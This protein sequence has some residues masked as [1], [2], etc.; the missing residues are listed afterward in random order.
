MHFG[1][2]NAP[3][4]FM[5]LM[6]DI[7]RPFTNSFVVVYLDDILIFNKSWAEHLQH[8]QQVLNTLWQQ[9]LYVNLEK[10]SFG[11]TRVQYLGYIMDEHGVH[12]DPTKIQAIR[13]W[14]APTTL[15]ELC[16]FLG[17]AN[18]YLRFMLGFSHIAWVPSQV[19][20]GGDKVKF[21]WVESL[22]KAFEELKHRLRL[23]SV[24]SLPNLQH[25]F[26][27]ETNASDYVVGIVL[28]QH[29]HPMAY[30]SETLSNA[31]RKYTTYDK[32]MYSIVTSLS[33]MEA[34]HSQKVDGHPH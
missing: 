3:T 2:T 30:H 34:L 11:M 24:L 19:T 5:I 29:G 15:T 21:V 17:L 20:K 25:P 9:Q 10:C 16:S 31:V 18:F 28:T 26:K 22:Q 23:A 1:F 7:F 27:M 4:T 14:S 32:E 13:D 6:G 12:V 33:T 8:I